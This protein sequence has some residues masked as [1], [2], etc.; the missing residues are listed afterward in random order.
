MCGV[1]SPYFKV[2]AHPIF[3]MKKTTFYIICVIAFVLCVWMLL[4]SCQRTGVDYTEEQRYA[5]T[6]TQMET[7]GKVM[8]S[9]KRM[10]YGDTFT[11]NMITYYVSCYTKS[12]FQRYVFELSTED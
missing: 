9:T 3:T 2:L 4:K 7:E 6:Y 8:C 11:A 1:L 5:Y 10:E 12:P